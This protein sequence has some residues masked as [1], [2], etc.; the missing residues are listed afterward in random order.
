MIKKIFL[1][2]FC[3]I[4]L[5]SCGSY[6]AMVYS[7]SNMR[8]VDINMTKDEVVAIMGSSYEVINRTES[9]FTLGYKSL[10]DGIYMLF[11]ENDL[12]KSWN[13]EWLVDKHK[14]IHT[15]STNESN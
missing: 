12:L 10:D 3:V 5:A 6:G 13:K 11:F 9:T 8:K 4:L 7:D 2:L 14:V 1:L 15:T